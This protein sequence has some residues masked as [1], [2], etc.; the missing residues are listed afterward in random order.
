M[1]MLH[2]QIQEEIKEALKAKETIRLLVL[3]GLLSAF[4]NDLI[5]ARRKPNEI[6]SDKEALKVIQK[7][8]KQRK[9][10]IEQFEKGDRNDLA[11][12]EKVELTILETY[13]PE[14]MS[15]EEIEKIVTAKKEEMG[16]V[17]KAKAGILIGGVMKELQGKADGTIVKEIVDKLFE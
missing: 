9:D 1:S 3:R 4:T 12:K 8:V 5:A 16:I 2:T 14:I 15:K 10:S 17:D 13:L 6:L 7:A 11:E